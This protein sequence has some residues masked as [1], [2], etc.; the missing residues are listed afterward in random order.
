TIATILSQTR[1]F[2][3]RLYL[4]AQS[5]VQIDSPRLTGALENCRLL[6]AFGLGRDSAAIQA[7]HIGRI[8]PYLI[9]E[10]GLT[11][12]QHAQYLSLGEQF[13]GWTSALQALSPRQAY[14]KRHN[15]PAVKITTL[16]VP[17]PAVDARE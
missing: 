6:I 11:D 7:R 16:T 17:Q 5:L 8:D 13:E 12:T 4:A 1:K 9:K 3:L 2:N 14:V 15:Q 10:A